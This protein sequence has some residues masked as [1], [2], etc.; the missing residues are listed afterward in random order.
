LAI[1]SIGITPTSATGW[2]SAT[3]SKGKRGNMARS[4]ACEIV[5]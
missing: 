3:G 5:V 2:R 1:S 4:A